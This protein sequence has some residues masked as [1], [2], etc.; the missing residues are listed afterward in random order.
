M[1]GT[2]ISLFNDEK[3][4]ITLPL[5]VAYSLV[6]GWMD[7]WFGKSNTEQRIFWASIENVKQFGAFCLIS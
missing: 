1:T 7:E 3:S 6:F 2:H 4:F 5:G